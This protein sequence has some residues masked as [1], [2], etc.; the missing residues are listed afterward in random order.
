M[1]K[2]TSRK[3]MRKTKLKLEPEWEGGLF[4]TYLLTERVT[5]SHSF[6]VILHGFPLLTDAK[7][8]F[9]CLSESCT[10]NL[11]HRSLL[12]TFKALSH[13][14]PTSYFGDEFPPLS[15]CSSLVNH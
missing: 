7:V 9:L 8:I 14:A 1:L 15:P 10:L 5:C 12:N 6:L 2:T 13:F 11:S 3:E 4:F